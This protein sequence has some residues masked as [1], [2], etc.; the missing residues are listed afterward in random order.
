MDSCA[1]ITPEDIADVEVTFDLKLPAQ[2]QK[3]YLSVNGGVPEPYVFESDT[4]DTVVS[5]F[6][7]LKWKNDTAIDVYLGLVRDKQLVPKCFFPFAVDG[8]GDYFFVDTATPDGLVYFYRHDTASSDPLLN[9]R[10]GFDQFWAL[11][12]DAT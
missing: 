9:L 11:L 1:A 3:L 12:R 10:V 6:L 2:V 7:P 4:L 8:G 5:E